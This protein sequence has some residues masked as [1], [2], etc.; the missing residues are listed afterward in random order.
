MANSAQTCMDGYHERFSWRVSTID[1]Y[2]TKSNS[3]ILLVGFLP[4]ISSKTRGTSYSFYQCFPASI[5]GM[6]WT[7][8][9]QGDVTVPE[10]RIGQLAG[11]LDALNSGVTTI[12][13]H[14]HAAN[15]PEHADA[16]L[17]ATIQ[18]GAR[19]ILSMARQS[20]PT[21]VFPHIEFGKE[22]ESDEWQ[23]RKLEEWASR[24]GG[25]LTPDGRVLLGFAWVYHEEV[26]L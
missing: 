9:T 26:T 14:F 1:N 11:C 22:A 23:W 13:D 24:G 16:V 19:V 5:S 20:A 7:R 15:S 8:H 2:L 25:R 12:L 21:Q 4:N 17:D 3:R 6:L 10:I 18:S